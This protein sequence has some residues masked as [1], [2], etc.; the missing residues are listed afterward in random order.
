MNG[1]WVLFL[2]A[3]L[4]SVAAFLLD[5][6]DIRAQVSVDFTRL[7]LVPNV[8]CRKDHAFALHLRGENFPRSAV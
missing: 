3:V 8:A 5:L 1:V 2:S 7:L 6:S 4:I